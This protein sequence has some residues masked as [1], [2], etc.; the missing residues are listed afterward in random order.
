MNVETI[1]QLF[2]GIGIVAN[3]WKI[4]RELGELAVAISAMK[5]IVKDHETRLRSLEV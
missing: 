1:F 2:I 4:Q 5:D 3:L